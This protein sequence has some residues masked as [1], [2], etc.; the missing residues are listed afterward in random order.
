MHP[1]PRL[2]SLVLS[3]SG[4]ALLDGC[5]QLT[6]EEC[7]AQPITTA[8]MDEV[9]GACPT[10]E[11]ATLLFAGPPTQCWRSDVAVAPGCTITF[12][13]TQQG[14]WGDTGST[15]TECCYEGG[16]VEVS[17]P[18]CVIG[19]PL[20]V[21]GR[22][23][24]GGVLAGRTA[25]PPLLP[26]A[27]ARQLA[28]AWTHIASLEHAAMAAFA[29]AERLLT[30]W[31]APHDLIHATRAARADE[32]RHAQAAFALASRY[33]GRVLTPAPLPD[34]GDTPTLA[35]FAVETLHDAAVGEAVAVAQA[36]AA[37]RGATDPQVRALLTRIIQDEARH[38]ALGLA[39]LAWCVQTGGDEVR[40]AVKTAT[41][42]PVAL[43]PSSGAR[44]HPVL[45]AHGVPGEAQLAHA[46]HR[47]LHEVA[48]PGV[49][50]LSA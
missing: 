9:D 5:T 4:V 46:A 17:P 12:K 50:A 36:A 35:D 1:Y 48:L 37:L 29:R 3:L 21:Q 25:T 27:Q 47:A 2:A 22:A 6:P 18:E 40:D 30:A 49:A 28:A 8:C 10:A 11:E 13:A 39:T 41:P 15:F 16:F 23:V 7:A 31:N 38:A 19:R 45:V 24:T 20:R 42:R 44:P 33:A 26:R 43:Q 32:V 14:D 34:P